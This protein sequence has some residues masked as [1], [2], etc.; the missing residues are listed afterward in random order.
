[1]HRLPAFA[2][3]VLLAAPALGGASSGALA[4]GR[5]S[6][7]NMS[8]AQAQGLVASRGAIVLS[9]GQFTYDRFVSN[10]TFC[11]PEEELIPT[12]APTRDNPQCMVGFRCEMRRN[13]RFDR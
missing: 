11:T 13:W 2:V 9:T 4:Q 6:T 12:W 7:L 8:C 3:T 10:Q 5:P 1:M